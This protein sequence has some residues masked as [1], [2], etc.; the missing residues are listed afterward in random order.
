MISFL[1]VVGGCATSFQSLERPTSQLLLDQADGKNAGEFEMESG[2]GLIP[3]RIVSPAGLRLLKENEGEVRCRSNA[4]MHCPYNDSS[5]YCTIGHGH[6]IA[7]K[8]CND[9]R[10]ELT[11][12]EYIDGI[13]NQ[14][15][16]EL[17]VEDLTLAQVGIERHIDADGRVGTA[18][19]SDAQYDALVSFVFNV[20]VANF[21][22]STLLKKLRA[23]AQTSG[24]QQVAYQFSRWRKSDGKVVKGLVNRRKREVEYFF[25]GFDLPY[26]DWDPIAIESGNIG[27][28]FNFIDVQLGE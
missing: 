4:D 24:S 16:E 11:K 14:K 9:I 10:L 27:D 8:N 7:K 6:L 25:K 18:I 5:N 1:M 2:E 13:S 20:G 12:L 17:L 21:H 23:R 19:L 3:D 28:D 26:L 22:S 15:A